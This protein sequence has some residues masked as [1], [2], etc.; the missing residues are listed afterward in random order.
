MNKICFVFILL[1]LPLCLTKGLAQETNY[2]E[3]YS[4]YLPEVRNFNKLIAS[5]PKGGPTAAQMVK[6]RPAS[7][8]LPVNFNT[9]IKPTIKVIKGPVNNDISLVIFKPGTVRAVVLEIHGGGWFLGSAADD[10]KFC[11]QI[12]RECKVAVVSV[13]YRLAPENPFPACVQDCEAAAKWL[14]NNSKKAF[15][16][17]K[18]LP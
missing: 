12:A 1:I 14:V 13:N 6:G 15:G 7:S 8:G 5:Q 11:D 17:D 9:I 10:A 2:K 16:T 4:A 3:D 18:L